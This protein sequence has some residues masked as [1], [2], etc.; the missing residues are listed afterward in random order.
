MKKK[1]WWLIA[2]GV[3]GVYLTTRNG[4]HDMWTGISA[5]TIAKGVGLF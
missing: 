4:N 3:A 1:N 2:A 5:V